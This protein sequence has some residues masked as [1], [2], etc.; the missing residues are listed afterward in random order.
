MI[1]CLT[2]CPHC[3]GIWGRFPSSAWPGWPHL[4]SAGWP[5]GCPPVHPASKSSGW[6]YTA[7]QPVRSPS[8]GDPLT[9]WWLSVAGGTPHG[10]Q[11]QMERVSGEGQLCRH[12]SVQTQV[13]HHIREARERWS[14]SLTWC[15]SIQSQWLCDRVPSRRE[16]RWLSSTNFNKAFI[17]VTTSVWFEETHGKVMA[18]PFHGYNDK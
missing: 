8:S 4:P 14:T 17:D 11:T 12:C 7:A 2:W 9:Y 13:V 16:L 3:G 5:I 18:K 6:S 1:F 10:D 15:S